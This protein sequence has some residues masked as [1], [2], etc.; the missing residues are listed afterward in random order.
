MSPFQGVPNSTVSISV[1]GTSQRVQIQTQASNSAVLVANNGSAVAFI[2]FG[3]SAVDA[4]VPSGSTKG[5]R[6]VLPGTVEV[7]R[8]ASTHV[9]A[10]A[11]GSTGSIYFT[12][13]EGI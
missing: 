1:S 9:A 11:A 13:G 2:T 4:T 8:L 5:G 12:P 7:M 3:D 6:P 10:I